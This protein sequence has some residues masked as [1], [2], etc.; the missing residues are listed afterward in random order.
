V[1]R[2]PRAGQRTLARSAVCLLALLTA[3]PAHALSASEIRTQTRQIGGA[4][5]DAAGE[6]RRVEQLGPLVLAFIEL[7]D[8][9]ARNGSEAQRRDELRGAFEAIYGPLN[10][11]YDARSGHLESL[12]H[13]VMDQ[14][15]DLEALYE[16][17]DFRES[18]ALA[19][20]ALYSPN[21]LDYYGARLAD[22]AR[23]KELLAAAEKGFSVRDRRAE[24]RADSR[25]SARAW[26]LFVGARRL[27]GGGATQAGHR[28]REGL[29]GA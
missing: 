15:G 14:D 17:K 5:G 3:I 27:R 26:P 12:A 22:G 10:G 25:K 21:W 2:S 11:I 29:A 6:Q 19:A 7:S 1:S 28:R 13:A 18:Q 4:G 8:D 20:Q 16:T 9:A 23:K 24:G